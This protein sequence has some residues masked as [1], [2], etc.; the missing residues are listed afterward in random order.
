M[1]SSNTSHRQGSVAKRAGLTIA[2]ALGA[3]AVVPAMASAATA[4]FAGTTVTYAGTSS[5]ESVTVSVVGPNYRFVQASGMTAAAGCTQVAV[6]TTVDCPLDPTTSVVANLNTGTD[7]FN[8]SAVSPAQDPFTINGDGDYDTITG[9]DANDMINGGNG[10]DTLTRRSRQRHDQ[11]RQRRRHAERGRR[12]RHAER[13][14]RQRHGEWRQ[15]QR[16]G[17]RER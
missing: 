17:V 13:E 12:Q 4:G 11:R 8:A 9:S 15:R 2:L 3:L 10:T 5:G 6:G 14:P 7:T 1:S 16:R